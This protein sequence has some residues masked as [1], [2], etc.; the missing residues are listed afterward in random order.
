MTSKQAGALAARSGSIVLL[1]N[2][3]AGS[4]KG[5]SAVTDVIEELTAEGHAI[6]VVQTVPPEQM[7]QHIAALAQDCDLLICMGGDGTLNQVIDS[8]LQLD[9]RPLLGY[10]A[11]GTTCDFARTLGLPIDDFALAARQIVH[12]QVGTL[13]AGCLND[14]HFA[15][16]ASFGAFT[17]V[18]TGTPRQLKQNLGHVAYF[19]EGLR[20]LPSIKPIPVKVTWEDGELNTPL[21]FGAVSNSTSIGG[22]LRLSE[23]DVKMD[24][25]LFECMLIKQPASPI[26]TPTMLA[27]LMNQ[28][29]SDKNI[30][31][32]SCKELTFSFDNPVAW[33]VDGEIAGD[34]L[35][36]RV[37][38]LYHALDFVF[39]PET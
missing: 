5:S 34:L 2:Y 21:I 12:G 26:E 9:H 28:D 38:N 19:L 17:Q 27:K 33:T 10:I 39:P 4:F 25:G 32:F 23:E 24:D 14:R 35:N 29:Y 20:S 31:F 37:T 30:L 16:V 7:P 6:K 15:Y 18:A 3:F 8:L 1:I 11:A 13:D 36:A 22:M